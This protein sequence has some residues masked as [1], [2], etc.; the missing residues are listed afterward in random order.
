MQFLYT[1]YFII[2]KPLKIQCSSGYQVDIYARTVYG[3]S[4]W[5]DGIYRHQM[6]IFSNTDI[7]IMLLV[8]VT[9]TFLALPFNIYGIKILARHSRLYVYTAIFCYWPS[10]W[11]FYMNHWSC[12]KSLQPCSF[13]LVFNGQLQTWRL[14]DYRHFLLYFLMNLLMLDSGKHFVITFLWWHHNRR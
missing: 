7:M 11:S 1:I 9:G 10:R 4:F 14:K 12:I 13:L 5:L 2:V 3:A 8:A 6:A